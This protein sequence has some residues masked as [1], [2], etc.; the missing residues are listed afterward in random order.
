MLSD[1]GKMP[2]RLGDPEAAAG[3]SLDIRGDLLTC[4]TG[5]L[6]LLGVETPGKESDLAGEAGFFG[7]A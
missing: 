4:C 1:L 5:D 7:D 2:T 3:F 6:S